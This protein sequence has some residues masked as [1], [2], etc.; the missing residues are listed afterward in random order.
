MIKVIFVYLLDQI[1]TMICC[2]NCPFKTPEPPKNFEIKHHK[3]RIEFNQ[4]AVLFSEDEKLNGLYCIEKGVC[5]ISKMGSNGRDQIIELLS[6]GTLL[7]IRSILNSENT[8]LKA[9]AITPIKACFIPKRFFLHNIHVKPDFALYLL[10]LLSNYIKK[11][12]DKIVEL[13]QKTL[14]QRAAKLLLDLPHF[15]D[16]D[17]FGYIDVKLRR[18]DMANMIGVA[19]ESFIRTLATF[20][21]KGMIHLQGK[22]IVIKNPKALMQITKGLKD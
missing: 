17:A 18:E 6:G 4:N 2:S 20:Q 7:G 21:K 11:T 12:D 22:R 14:R 16:S 15:F 9:I 10:Q 1:H 3:H 5:R 8:N 19:T 13:G